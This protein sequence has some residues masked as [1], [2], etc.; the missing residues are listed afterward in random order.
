MAG[1]RRGWGW[2]VTDRW[3]K[4]TAADCGTADQGAWEQT[5]G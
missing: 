1:G 3:Q 2:G 4:K 5:D